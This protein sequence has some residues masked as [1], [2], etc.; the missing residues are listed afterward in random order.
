MTT[1]NPL[2]DHDECLSM[3]AK[4]GQLTLELVAYDDST[5][6]QYDKLALAITDTRQAIDVAIQLRH[7]AKPDV[8]ETAEKVY[9]EALRNPDE[10][11][12]RG[13]I[14]YLDHL[15]GVQ[16]P[17]VN[18]QGKTITLGIVCAA[19]MTQFDA[20]GAIEDISPLTSWVA[21]Q[22]AVPESSLSVYPMPGMPDTIFE[23]LYDFT[24]ELGRAMSP[25]APEDYFWSMAAESCEGNASD[26]VFWVSI[27]SDDAE[28][29]QRISDSIGNSV[30]DESTGPVTL[31]L[32]MADGPCALEMNPYA[33]TWPF[34]AFAEN[35]FNPV[36]D[37]LDDTV[38][39]LEERGFPPENIDAE[40]TVSLEED[41][42]YGLDESFVIELRDTVTGFILARV[43]G[44]GAA[45][46][47]MFTPYF[48]HAAMDINFADI[49][50]RAERGQ[51]AVRYEREA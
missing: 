46:L 17:L 8:L 51:P 11:I 36:L 50:V 18:S 35:A 24:A 26:I 9:A 49:V 33:I 38:A 40:L 32:K 2:V 13:L 34:S 31:H 27:T 21:K 42:L 47:E 23:G 44:F 43:P 1:P 15:A 45:L 12:V 10:D 20:I 37:A 30:A 48:V 4:L 3:M 19:D 39:R 25:L 28:E 22:L 14:T 7:W 6:S 16:V 29:L 5:M 41:T